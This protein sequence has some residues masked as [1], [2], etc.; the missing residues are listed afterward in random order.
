MVKT[1]IR[2]G[3]VAVA[4]G[5]L[6]FGGRT[7]RG[8]EKRIILSREGRTLVLEPYAPNI[9]RI[10]MSSEKTSALAAAGYGFVGEPAMTGWTQ[11]HDS[12]GYDIIR[13]G[14]MIV[15]VSPGYATRSIT[16]G[17][18]FNLDIGEPGRHLDR[19]G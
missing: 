12:S 6:L 3:A 1:S 5:I 10:T 4:I 14:R 19:R 11:D 13:S 8:A 9:I 2:R 16:I 15:H 7:L 18:G 17:Y